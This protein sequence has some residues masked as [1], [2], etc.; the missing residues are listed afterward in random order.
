MCR[1]QLSDANAAKEH[2]IPNALGGQ[3]WTKNATCSSCNSRAGHSLDSHLVSA[4]ALLANVFDVPRD[5][6]DHPDTF[7]K[8]TTT[9]LNYR[10]SPGER[11]VLAHN[12]SFGKEADGTLR[13]T[14]F[15]PTKEEA[16]RFLRKNLPKRA[17]TVVSEL[18]GTEHAG[19]KYT[20]DLFNVSFND[21]A[22]LRAVAKIASCYARHMGFPV[23]FSALAPQF[24]RGEPTP[25]VPVVAAVSDVVAIFN[26]DPQPLHHAV[27]LFKPSRTTHLLAYVVLFHAFEF[28]VLIDENSSAPTGCAGYLWN[29]VTALPEVHDFSWV[30]NPDD[31]IEW[32]R[33]RPPPGERAQGRSESLTHWI[34]NIEAV[35]IQRAFSAAL[36]EFQRRISEGANEH[37]ALAQVNAEMQS[38]LAPYGLSVQEIKITRQ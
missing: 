9:G 14:F 32:V 26:L 7:L 34:R 27:F 11:P 30:A 12:I 6:G 1:A 31:L 35:W 15:A 33:Q 22:L 17:K 5:R 3:L 18:V 28:V 20:L 23:P 2:V 21:T 37:D 25:V 8:D 4:L 38:R 13:Y 36:R 10:L 29:V 24:V 16:E 19:G